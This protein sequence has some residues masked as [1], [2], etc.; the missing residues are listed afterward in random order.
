MEVAQLKFLRS[1]KKNMYESNDFA[2][3]MFKTVL[4]V[5]HSNVYENNYYKKYKELGTKFDE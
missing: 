3:N 4:F 5:K 1:I 2:V